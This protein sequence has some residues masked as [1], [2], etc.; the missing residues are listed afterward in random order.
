MPVLPWKQYV[1]GDKL[2]MNYCR[3]E[4]RS[5]ELQTEKSTMYAYVA[6]VTIF[7]H[8]QTIQLI[9]TTLK[10]MFANYEVGIPFSAKVLKVSL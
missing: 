7:P 10:H 3:L 5:E 8:Q 9:V 2:T 4:L 6:M 1:H